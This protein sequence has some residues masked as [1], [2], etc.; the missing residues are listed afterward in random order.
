SSL[1]LLGAVLRAHPGDVG[2]WVTS[3][4]AAPPRRI[5]GKA[6]TLQLGPLS[7]ASARTLVRQLRPVSD[8]ALQS[9]VERG[10][11]NP[12]FLRELARGDASAGSELPESINDVVLA[13]ID[14]LPGETRRVLG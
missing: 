8:A 13:R 7:H 2:V 11:G 14:Q 4:D 12:L 1:E 10:S 9:I 3:R 5:A 6:V